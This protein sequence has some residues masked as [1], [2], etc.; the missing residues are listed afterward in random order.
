MGIK[1][2]DFSPTIVYHLYNVVAD[3]MSRAP[4]G[5]AEEEEYKEVM[6]PPNHVKM[7][8]IHIQCH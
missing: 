3:A 7:N 4:V 1:I 5:H 8:I 6:D 2:Q